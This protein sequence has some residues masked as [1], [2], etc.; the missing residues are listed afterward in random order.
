MKNFILLVILCALLCTQALAAIPPTLIYDDGVLQGVAFKQNY[1]GNLNVVMTGTIANITA[2][3]G[4]GAG[5]GDFLADGSVPMTANLD[6]GGFAIDNSIGM[7]SDAEI[8]FEPYNSQVELLSAYGSTIT[9]SLNVTGN[10][11]GATYASDGSVSD[12]ELK[13][14]G[15]TPGGELGGTW[16]S[17]TIDDNVTVD[18]WVLGNSTA[19]TLN[20]VTV[21][22]P[23]GGSTL[24]IQ[25]EKT[26]TVSDDTTLNGGTHS[27]TNTGDNDEVNTKTSGDLC[28]NDGSVVNCTVNTIAELETAL[29]AENILTAT[30][31][32][33][34]Y[35]PIAVTDEVGTLTNGDM[36]TNDGT[37]VQCTVNTEAE[38]ETAMDGLNFL[39]ETEIDAS[40][41]LLALMDDE[42]GSASGSPLLVFNQNPTINAMVGTGLADFGGADL[43]LPQDQTA[44]SVGEIDF[45][46]TDKTLVVHDG[47]AARVYGESLYQQTACYYGD[48]DWTA[49]SDLLIAR[50]PKN[51]AATLVEV[52]MVAYGSTCRY[53]INERAPGSE[54]TPAAE[55]LTVDA[56]G[57]TTGNTETGFSDSSTA[58]NAGLYLAPEV[59]GGT[60]TGFC[61]TTRYY[62]N[63]E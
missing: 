58:A 44:D 23:A 39:L 30:E 36:C 54:F 62:K 22:Q 42:T 16:A 29:D 6:N 59:E 47:T 21:T 13:V 7:I 45:D 33:A 9:G 50:A 61:A 27:G 32:D 28:I 12:A 3:L 48:I 38:F 51:M 56:V 11:A 4:A 26:L 24:T 63:V 57:A 52:Y 15:T 14:I 60:M 55:I 41:E 53:N 37:D 35:A 20:L 49:Q 31:G 1:A 8:S 17:P 2:T 25:N 5:T 18:G 40:S 46:T 19:T 34:A 43:E 10:V